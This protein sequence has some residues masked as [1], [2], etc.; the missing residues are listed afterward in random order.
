M[1]LVA[2]VA[3]PS[4]MHAV[5]PIDLWRCSLMH[6]YTVAHM[7]VPGSMFGTPPHRWNLERAEQCCTF[8]ARSGM[9]ALPMTEAA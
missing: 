9:V 3:L 4:V 1:V 6:L 8:S 7:L 2:V 5:L